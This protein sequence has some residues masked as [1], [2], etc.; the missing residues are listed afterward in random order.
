MANTSIAQHTKPGANLWYDLLVRS[1]TLI[2]NCS[3]T[4]DRTNEP[5]AHGPSQT[6]D[7]GL[8]GWG[9]GSQ[10]RR[11]QKYMFHRHV[12]KNPLEAPA[13]GPNNLKTRSA[14]STVSEWKSQNRTFLANEKNQSP[15]ELKRDL[16]RLSGL[17]GAPFKNRT[18]GPSMI[19]TRNYCTITGQSKFRNCSFDY[20]V[21]AF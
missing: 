18:R 8:F 1:L 13:K 12:H 16:V 10:Q 11:I 19:T 7:H 21:D 14:F 2:Y 17:S 6:M 4:F 20:Y 3:D 9:F 5:V 15:L